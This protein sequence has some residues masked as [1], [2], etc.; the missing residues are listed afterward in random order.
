MKFTSD[1]LDKIVKQEE[2]E[3]IWEIT[4]KIRNDGSLT[5]T[6]E[7]IEDLFIRLKETYYYLRSLG[8]SKK[9]LIEAYLYGKAVTPGYKNNPLIKD[10]VE[11]K[12]E[13]PENQYEDLLIIADK[14]KKGLL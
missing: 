1:Q 10:W 5:L 13:I 7:N 11:K 9:N 8:F 6:E 4:N 12:N 14:M 2:E 3:V